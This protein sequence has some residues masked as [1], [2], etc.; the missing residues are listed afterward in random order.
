MADGIMSRLDGWEET[1]SQVQRD[2]IE[3]RRESDR[4]VIGTGTRYLRSAKATVAASTV[5]AVVAA[6]VCGVLVPHWWP[7]FALVACVP[8]VVGPTLVRPRRLLEIDPLSGG[9]IVCQ[10]M[11]DMGEVVTPYDV[12]AIEGRYETQGWDP[13]SLICA[14]CHESHEVKLIV[15]PGTD[16]KLAEY[17]C[18]LLGYLLDRPSHYEDPQGSIRMCHEPVTHP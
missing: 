18:K 8:P 12:V 6:V 14:M 16:E 13:R 11:A 3:V 10:S 1:T 5:L 7:A 2:L 17:L 15:L 9:I 4:V